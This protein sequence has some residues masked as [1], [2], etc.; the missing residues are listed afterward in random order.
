MTQNVTGLT[1]GNPA[2]EPFFRT[3]QEMLS[4]ASHNFRLIA[5]T[6][7]GAEIAVG[8]LATTLRVPA[9]AGHDQ[10]SLSIGGK[11]RYVTANVDRLVTGI[12][13]AG[14][15]DIFATASAND[16]TGSEPTMDL[17]NYSFALAVVA[18]GGSPGGVALY[19][20][21]GDLTWSGTAITRLRQTVAA[22]GG[23]ATPKNFRT[24]H[25]FTVGGAVVVPSGN[26]D[27]IPPMAVSRTNTQIVKL[28]ALYWRLGNAAVGTT[29][30]FKVQRNGADVAG[31]A[32]TTVT[33]PVFAT[34]SPTAVELAD[35]DA[36]AVVVTAIAGAGAAAPRNLSVV[37]VLDHTV[38]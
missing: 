28:A 13:A 16:F 11:Y 31:F 22:P 38:N 2:I 7:G 30:S 35:T 33:T 12:G 5:M 23:Y 29:V 18:S 37:L 32:Q 14:E 8:P 25:T 36:L 34:T 6:T 9:G 26:L 20:K 15:Y 19:R 10:V 17:T 21:V 1:K 24:S 27:V 4:G 3:V